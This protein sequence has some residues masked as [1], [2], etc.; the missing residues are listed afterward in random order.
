MYVWKRVCVACVRERERTRQR[1]RERVC[2]CA[3]EREK[4]AWSRQ[5]IPCGMP[6]DSM[7][8]I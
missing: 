1:D 7:C 4:Q 2:V 5:K 8:E 6:Q 3:K